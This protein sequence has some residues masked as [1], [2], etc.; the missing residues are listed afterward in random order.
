MPILSKLLTLLLLL[1]LATGCRLFQTS[2]TPTVKTKS[3]YKQTK[4]ITVNPVTGKI[5]HR[6]V[7]IYNVDFKITLNVSSNGLVE[8]EMSELNAD[9]TAYSTL[10]VIAEQKKIDKTKKGVNVT[11]SLL[12]TGNYHP[13]SPKCIKDVCPPLADKLVETKKQSKGHIITFDFPFDKFPELKPATG[14]ALQMAPPSYKEFPS[15]NK[16]SK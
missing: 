7:A 11:L 13:L 10:H 2:S 14:I 6:D 16:K 5:N 15:Q 8:P 9:K 3:L 12:H 1:S 4:L